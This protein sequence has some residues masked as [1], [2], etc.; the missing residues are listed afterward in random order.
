MTVLRF[1]LLRA[2]LL[3]WRLYRHGHAGGWFG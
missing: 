1:P 2:V 3:R